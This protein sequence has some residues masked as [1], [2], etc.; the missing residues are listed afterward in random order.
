MRPA[1]AGLLALGW[2]ALGCQAEAGAPQR[3]PDFHAAAVQRWINSAPLDAD[4][5]RG[6]PVLIE[7]WTFGCYNCR[8]TLPWM[9]RIAERYA[10]QGLVMVAVHTPEFAA[11]RGRTAV[12]AAVERLG[13]AY[14]VLLDDD[15]SF[16]AAMG[17]R[18]WPAFY[19]YDGQGNLVSSRIGE[20]HAGRR[21]ADSFEEQIQRAIALSTGAT[22]GQGD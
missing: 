1:V 17:N 14:P 12:T 15:A 18:Y 6:H 16:W 10:S 8:N 2:L 13:V 20:L 7:F 11:E 22:P 4:A 5:L 9:K 21:D 19:L 3:L